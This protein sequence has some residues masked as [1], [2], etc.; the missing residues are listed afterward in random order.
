MHNLFFYIKVAFKGYLFKMLTLFIL[1]VFLRLFNISNIFFGI[2]SILA[3][4][5]VGGY[6]TVNYKNCND[7][8]NTLY[9]VFL[10]IL[11]ITT[12]RFFY[13]FVDDPMIYII[14]FLSIIFSLL[15]G[16]IGVRLNKNNCNQ[17]F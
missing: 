15:G 10:N 6:I 4:D 9:Y 14:L 7:I 13:K 3:S 1:S 17:S 12:Y 16:F 2:F 5:L 8:K 11:I